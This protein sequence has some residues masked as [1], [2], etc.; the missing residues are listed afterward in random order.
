MIS[1]DQGR[2]KINTLPICERQY[3]VKELLHSSSTLNN[4]SVSLLSHILLRA[5]SQRSAL[6]Y[7]L[8]P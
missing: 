7:T 1:Y 6:S 3:S 8:L 2:R 4:I 5:V